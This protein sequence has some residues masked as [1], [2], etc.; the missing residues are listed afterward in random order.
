MT[1]ANKPN[2][3][4]GAYESGETGNKANYSITISTSCGDFSNP[5]TYPTTSTVVPGCW[6]NK[7]A[8]KG[9][10]QWNATGATCVLQN[11]KTYYLNFINGDISLVQPNGGGTA[12][13][14][15]TSGC[16]GGTC[17]LPIYNGPGTWAG[18][19]PQ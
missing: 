7:L 5:A 9:L 13:S 4:Y 15:K 19:T 14:T 3:L 8:T 16:S 17:E 2:P 12:S 6:K 18:Y 11:N 10:L 1:A